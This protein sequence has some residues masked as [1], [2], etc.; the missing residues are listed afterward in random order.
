MA[1]KSFRA[2][3]ARALMDD[4]ALAGVL[5]EIEEQAVKDFLASGGDVARMAAAHERV[6]AV[7]TLRDAL[8]SRITDQAI[9]EKRENDNA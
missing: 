3:Q 4:Q 5:Q 7:T 1:D 8:Q 6:R 9:A 2:A